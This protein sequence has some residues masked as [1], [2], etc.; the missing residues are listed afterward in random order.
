MEIAPF[1]PATKR[2]F[3]PTLPMA[4]IVNAIFFKPSQTMNLS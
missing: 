3:Q 1:I 2:G 4:E